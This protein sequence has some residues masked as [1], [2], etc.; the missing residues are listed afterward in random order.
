VERAI[1]PLSPKQV[2]VPIGG[3]RGLKPL[4][5]KRLPGKL[6]EKVFDKSAK[7]PVR[8]RFIGCEVLALHYPNK[9]LADENFYP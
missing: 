7:K 1:A 8:S 3:F 5:L 2:S 9:S 4:S 6:S